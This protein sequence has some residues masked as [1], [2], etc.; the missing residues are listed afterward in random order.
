MD[1]RENKAELFKAA[2]NKDLEGVKKALKNG[3]NVNS[4]DSSG[5][6]A[7]MGASGAGYCEVTKLLAD[8][9]ADLHARDNRGRTALRNAVYWGHN[10]IADVLR[11]AGAT[12]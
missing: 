2:M 1:S 10:R 9:G 4:M 3:A 7:L 5:Y 11:E 6:T 12:E 8:K